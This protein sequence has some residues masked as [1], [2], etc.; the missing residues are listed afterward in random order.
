LQTVTKDLLSSFGGGDLEPSERV[1]MWSLDHEVEEWT[2][3]SFES[4]PLA[5]R[6]KEGRRAGDSEPE[7]VSD[8]PDVKNA[9]LNLG[10]Q[11]GVP[12]PLFWIEGVQ[13][14]S[15]CGLGVH[16]A[17]GAYHSVVRGL[18]EH[19]RCSAART[20]ATL[21]SWGGTSCGT[22]HMRDAVRTTRSASTNPVLAGGGSQ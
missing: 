4:D 7:A 18:P 6:G 13:V 8:L 19:D 16:L 22:A 1:T 2:A 11:R 3:S 12:I 15:D 9:S 10:P 17:S 20:A 5:D 14:A 21:N